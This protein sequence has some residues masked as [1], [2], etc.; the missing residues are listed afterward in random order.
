MGIRDI[1]ISSCSIFFFWAGGY[2]Y[3]KWVH[4]RYITCVCIPVCPSHLELVLSSH[5]RH[6]VYAIVDVIQDVEE[7]GLDQTDRH[8]LKT[9][10][11]EHYST[12]KQVAGGG[13]EGVMRVA[14]GRV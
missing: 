3:S 4:G 7:A 9:P 2:S 8:L 1:G 13:T 6:V 14:M 5:R 11:R 10:S 12:R